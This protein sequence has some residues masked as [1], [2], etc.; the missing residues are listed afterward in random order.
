MIRTIMVLLVLSPILAH[1]A[2]GEVQGDLREA[3]GIF[4][5]E[6]KSVLYVND[7]EESAPFYR[8]VLGFGFQGFANL[9]DKPYYAEMSVAGIKFGLH[10]PTS[11]GQEKKVGQQR[12]YF[13]VKDLRAQPGPYTQACPV[14]QVAGVP[15]YSESRC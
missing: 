2:S 12:L 8:D 11:A 5:G 10:E 7:V 14:H 1:G 9:D 6:M 3:H 13:R 15:V 4:T